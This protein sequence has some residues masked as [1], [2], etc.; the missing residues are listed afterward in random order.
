MEL[1]FLH[2]GDYTDDG[3]MDGC[4]QERKREEKGGF[5]GINTG[6]APSGELLS[7]GSA[8][9]SGAGIGGS[10]ASEEKTGGD[11]CAPDIALTATVA[12]G[13]G[14][15]SFGKRPPIGLAKAGSCP[16]TSTTR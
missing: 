14:P 2:R 13:S 7:P 1:T 11:G 12:W 6:D 16:V 9:T 5:S 10:R 4:L 8:A 15:A 3:G